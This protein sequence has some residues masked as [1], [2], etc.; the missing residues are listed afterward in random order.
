MKK[1]LIITFI[2]ISMTS[3][4]IYY[5]N[6]EN[7]LLIKELSHKNNIDHVQMIN[8]SNVTINKKLDFNKE[9]IDVKARIKKDDGIIIILEEE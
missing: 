6:K 9:D 2:F 8:S 7:Q 4:V 5:F 3:M 1:N